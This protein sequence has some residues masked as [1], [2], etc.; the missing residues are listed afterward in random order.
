V[1]GSDQRTD[2]CVPTFDEVVGTGEFHIEVVGTGEFH[3]EMMDC[4]RLWARLG[5]VCLNLVA[6][7]PPWWAPW[8]G[9]RL[10]VRAQ[11]D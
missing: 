6:I 8:R 5:D 4:D 11:R 1:I 3:I 9:A 7:A 10:F 2:K